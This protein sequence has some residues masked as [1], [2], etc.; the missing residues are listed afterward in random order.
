LVGARS[1]NFSFNIFVAE[2]IHLKK[3]FPFIFFI[4][5]AG[6]S[7][8][9]VPLDSTAQLQVDSGGNADTVRHTVVINQ[10]TITDMPSNE[11]VLHELHPK[12]EKFPD[13]PFF[14]K[15]IDWKTYTLAKSSNGPGSSKPSAPLHLMKDKDFLFY[16]LVMLLLLYAL[17][18]NSFPRYFSD[19]FRLFFRTTLKQRQIREQMMQTPLPSL[20]YNGL[21]VLSGGLYL[22]FIAAYFGYDKQTPFFIL[23]LYCCLALSVIYIIKFAGLL[24]TGWLF[25]QQEAAK[26]Y[27]FVVFI[28]NKMI[29]ILLLPFLVLLAFSGGD[30]YI[31]GLNLSVCL[32]IGLFIYRFI[33]TYTVVRNQV[34]VNPFHFFLY[35]CAFE[36]AP[37]FLIY[38]GLLLFFEQSA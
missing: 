20:L 5:C 22:A 17:I 3:I 11:E 1:G 38:K 15:P 7:N 4:C 30:L 23:M 12:T 14:N 28:V 8:A 2:S 13:D 16:A 32:V 21:F 24:F 34:R 25:Q 26:A 10:D 6:K 35:L 29:G 33:L 19:L 36:I 18:R 37:L 27:V 31:A 9:Q